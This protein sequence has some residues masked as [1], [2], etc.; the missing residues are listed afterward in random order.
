MFN[1]PKLEPDFTKYHLPEIEKA[2]LGCL[3]I[4]GNG[5]HTLSP[6]DL[7]ENCFNGEV[8]RTI[9]QCIVKYFLE[10]GHN[11]DLVSTISAMIQ[12]GK[13][14]TMQLT[15]MMEVVP[16]TTL[17]AGWVKELW[18]AMVQR[19]AV[20]LYWH[21]EE[22][23]V[24]FE[25]YQEKLKGLETSY[26]KPADWKNQLQEFWKNISTPKEEGAVLYSPFGEFNNKTGGLFPGE[27]VL[28]CGRTGKGK[29]ALLCSWALSLAKAKKKVAF[30]S[31]E[32]S[33]QAIISRWFGSELEID[34]KLFR[35]SK[36]TPEQLEQVQEVSGDWYDFQIFLEDRRISHLRDIEH[37]SRQVK[38]NVIFI[39]YIQRLFTGKG[40][41]RASELDF[42]I[43]RLKSL[44]VRQQTLVIAA[45]QLRRDVDTK[46]KKGNP[47][48]L[49]DIKDS[50]SLEQTA[51][52]VI[53]INTISDDMVNARLGLD[54]AKSRHTGRFKFEVDFRKVYQKFEEI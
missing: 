39:D 37:I 4:D 52:M 32:M 18:E 30:F 36:L 28:I 22:G 7:T 19:Q 38:P 27:L 10:N 1:K 51:D 26:R 11:P 54:V 25:E 31:L 35:L 46:E 44:A 13:N 21:W 5:D 49:Q 14:Y 47:V 6:F 33:N 15:G 23:R 3:L 12:E 9:Y 42:I 45:A 41:N 40:E 48:A 29:T 8:N 34:T 20:E 50:S 43:N 53:L 17:Y 24:T 16:S 2:T